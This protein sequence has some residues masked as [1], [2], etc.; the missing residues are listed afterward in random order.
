VGGSIRNIK[1][2]SVEY[3]RTN[4]SYEI[5]LMEFSYALS[6]REVMDLQYHLSWTT[7]FA[8]KDE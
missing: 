3:T 7:S 6:K 2:T 4:V 5:L 8:F 1:G